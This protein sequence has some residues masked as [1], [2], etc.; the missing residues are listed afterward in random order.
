MTS[1]G[2]GCAG[3]LAAGAAAPRSRARVA[4]ARCRTP[5][6]G[7]RSPAALALRGVDPDDPAADL[8]TFGD[9]LR[10]HRPGRPG[11]STGSWGLIT[12]AALNLHPD[13]A[14]LAL[15]ARVFR[16]GL[17]D[18]RRRRR[19]RH[20]RGAAPPAARRTGRPA[21]RRLGVRVHTKT[22]VTAV[23][24][25]P[26]RA[27][28]RRAGRTFGRRW[29]LRH[30]H[31]RTARSP[32]MPSSSPSP[33][34]RRRRSSRSVPR[35]DRHR[36]A[37]LGCV[38]DR[39]RPPALRPHGSPTCRSPPGSTRRCS[40]CSTGPASPASTTGS[41]SSSPS[42]PP[43]TASTSAA[44]SCRQT[45]PLALADLFPAA[46]Q[47]RVVESFVTREPHATFRQGPGTAA[48]RPDRR[49]PGCPASPW[50]APGPP[51]AGRTR[52]RAPSAAASS[53]PT[54]SA[55]PPRLRGGTID[56][57]LQDGRLT[58]ATS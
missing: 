2:R 6:G 12:V 44:D 29:R 45:S 58:E 21:V 11:R 39:Q 49:R 7:G 43:T 18:R 56:T 48:L 47:A 16:T 9:W 30:S 34:R 31:R 27:V 4:T 20:S 32:P 24:A 15:A 35:P 1:T 36:W 33:I 46:R 22:K 54:R 25:R 52:W 10:A 40:G 42:P 57:P 5:S 28:R 55:G 51:P 37:E 3:R 14:S 8:T 26:R 38:A 50:P 13:E 41:T 17:L 53:R 19:P 23:E